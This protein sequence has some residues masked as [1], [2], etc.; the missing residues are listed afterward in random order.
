MK[1]KAFARMDTGSNLPPLRGREA[2]CQGLAWGTNLEAKAAQEVI[3]AME[4]VPICIVADLFS[5]VLAG[6]AGAQ[7]ELGG[8]VGTEDS[9]QLRA[10]VWVLALQPHG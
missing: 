3:Q 7:H 1:R 8:R 2:L 6:R 5:P 9:G 4:R 10:H